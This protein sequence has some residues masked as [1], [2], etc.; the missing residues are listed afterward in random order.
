MK[1]VQC[2]GERN[3]INRGIPFCKKCGKNKPIC[4]ETPLLFEEDGGSPNAMK[5]AISVLAEFDKINT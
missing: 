2:H 3:Y 5:M 1:C 4:V